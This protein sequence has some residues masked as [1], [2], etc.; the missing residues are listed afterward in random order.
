[1]VKLTINGKQI[2]V[3]KG[4]SLIQACELAEV[5]IPRF[6][7]HDKLKVAGSCR[8]CLVEIEKMDK[9]VASCATPV[10]EGMVVHTDSEKVKKAREGAL[11][12]LLVN[13]PLEC[14]ICDQGGECDLQDQAMVYGKGASR[15]CENKRAVEDKNMGPLIETHMNRCIH[16]TRCVRFINDIAGTGELAVFGLGESMKISTYLQQVVTSELSGN[17]IDI[18]PVGALT[19]KPYAFKARNWELI[20]TESI[21]VLDAVGSNI[22]IDSRGPEVLRILPRL[23]EDINEEW[24]SDKT[25]FAYDGLKNQRLDKP[26]IKIDG[27]LNSV[28]WGEALDFIKTKITQIQAHEMAAI[29]GDLVDAESI[30]VLRDMMKSLGSPHIDC[31][32]E[33]VKL[34]FRHRCSYLFNSSIAGIEKSD[35][36][37]IIGANPRYEATMINARIRKRWLQGNYKIYSIGEELDLTYP[38][39]HLGDNPKLLE[40]ILQGKHK[41]SNALKK[42]NNPMI[43]LGYGALKREDWQEILYICNNISNKYGLIKDDWNGF[44]VLH[45]SASCVAALDL[46]FVPGKGGMHVDQIL[47]AT[48]SQSIKLLYLLA[49]DEVDTSILRNDCF[50]I[51]QGHHGDKSALIAD[52]ILPGAA[53][54]E[55]DAIYVNLEGRAQRTKKAVQAPG[56]AKEDWLILMLLANSL[57]IKLPYSNKTE[58]LNKL[59]QEALCFKK[60][61]SIVKTKWQNFGIKGNL[62][63]NRIEA[64]K[65]NYYLSDP[66]CRASRTMAKCRDQ[67]GKV[68]VEK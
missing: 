54:T 58:L 43:I 55:K 1:M 40:Q 49:A 27:K 21:D 7:Y 39:E 29:I 50:I 63:D 41:L 6:C 56:E 18:C 44:N 36:C 60:I 48:N 2:E 32:Q 17:M 65:M 15:F 34:D 11:E 47:E 12:F 19:S 4:L 10:S 33:G 62:L 28:S 3:E 20:K 66:I 38:V 24:I 26:Y 22:R 52:V 37:L 23:N 35:L 67:F 30:L 8:A 59:A 46:G 16:C 57:G 53:Y 31:M 61:G 9:L 68:G 5:E 51:Y 64:L 45:R 14:P 42:A 25:R 13:H